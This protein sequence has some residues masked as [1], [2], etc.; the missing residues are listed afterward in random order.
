MK[1]YTGPLCSR[2]GLNLGLRLALPQFDCE[3]CSSMAIGVHCVKAL[4]PGKRM[5]GVSW[6]YACRAIHQN[7]GGLSQLTAKAGSA[8]SSAA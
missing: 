4:H 1:S 2:A 7:I 5:I 6:T 8:I 3:L